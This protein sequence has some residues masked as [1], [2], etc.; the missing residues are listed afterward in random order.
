MVEEGSLGWHEGP[1]I[2]SHTFVCCGSRASHSELAKAKSLMTCGREP[3]QTQ[4][5]VG[6]QLPDV[7]WP[8]TIPNVTLNHSLFG[9]CNS[10]V[11]SCHLIG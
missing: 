11:Q 5:E 4:W 7:W 3:Q 2:Q 6:I 1:A 9:G 10:F 8:L